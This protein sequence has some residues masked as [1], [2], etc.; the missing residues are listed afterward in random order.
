ML[1]NFRDNLHGATKGILIAIIIVPFALFGVDALFMSGSAVEEAANVNG[2]T[3]TELRL[4][5]A[6]V[7]QKQQIL[8]RYENID[9]TLVDE[10]QLRAPVMQQLIRQKVV[11][12]AAVDQGM[13]VDKKTLY[14]IL[15]EVPDFQ[16]DG[17]FDTERY[18][19]VLR[20][21][22]YSPTSYNKL[23]TTDMVTNQFMQGVAATGFSTLQESTLLAG[24]T[25]QTRDYYY[26]TIPR[27]PLLESIEVAEAD[28]ESYYNSNQE[29]FR[30][31]E[32]LV[33]EYVELTPADFTE[34]V[35]LEQ[36]MVDEV[37][38]ARIAAAASRRSR[39]VAQ[40]LL[41]VQDDDSHLEKLAEI[42]KQLETGE[43]FADLAREYSEDYGTAEQGG[44][45]GYVQAGDLPGP[46]GA[47]LDKLAVGEVSGVVESD[48]GVHLLKLLDEK[49]ADVPSRE[50]LEPSV[51]QELMHQL[52]M[53]LLPV[54]IE[55]LKDLSYNA[56]SLE[57]V[58]NRLGVPLQV[59]EPFARSDGTGIS[60]NPIVAQAAFSK[61]VL[62]EGLASEVLE[63]AD[64]HVMVL[65]LKER[66]PETL[67]PLADVRDQ[68]KAMLKAQYASR[69]LQQ[70][71][72]AL[73]ERARS[74]DSI[75]DIAKQEELEW[76]VSLDTKRFSGNQNSQIRERVFEMPEPGETPV[77][78]NLVLN[79]GDYVLVSLVKV[80]EGDYSQLSSE[81]QK[82][83]TATV[84][85]TNASRDYQAYERTLL[86]QADVASKY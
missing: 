60:A 69:E 7:L 49:A 33:V 15:L 83:L 71:G 23:L 67:Q 25:E 32:K 50:Q 5:Q 2:E 17:K 48:L 37:V 26:L 74:G 77:V 54:R 68:I 51:R 30:S 39:H 79:N 1:Q 64:D 55:E 57:S 36:S 40:I 18:E 59:S 4:Q 82:L 72:E 27:E 24:I 61:P 42:Q 22:G 52:A 63:L 3:I 44:D 45:L 53:E 66:I 14:R 12:Q 56:D 38:D 58:A 62:S 73:A 70:R 84:A 46:L 86:E 85:L 19:F 81:Q 76:Q 29:E 31:E 13:G 10:D 11:E 65:K 80:Q 43:S 35:D 6:V 78:D 16:T 8:N 75:E 20:Q 9:P 34:E 21:M 28:I 41:E 47:T